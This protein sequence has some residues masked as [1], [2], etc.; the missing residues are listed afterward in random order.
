MSRCKLNPC[1]GDPAYCVPPLAAANAR[2]EAQKPNEPAASKSNAPITPLLPDDGR[3]T[4]MQVFDLFQAHGI[5]APPV[6]LRDEIVCLWLWAH[7][8]KAAADALAA[9]NARLAEEE[10]D[11][12]DADI[13][14]TQ[15]AYKLGETE[16]RL[17]EVEQQK[18]EWVNLF[19]DANHRLKKA[20]AR[21]DRLAEGKLAAEDRVNILSRDLLA[22]KKEIERLELSLP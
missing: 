22:A 18:D 4:W 19:T 1:C 15:L 12:K 2:A 21:V 13:Q 5:L 6:K 20:E 14:C 11:R 17:A 9:A 10:E 7:Y 8:G 16:A 3:A